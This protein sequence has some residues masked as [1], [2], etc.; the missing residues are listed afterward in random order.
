MCVLLFKGKK[1]KEDGGEMTDVFTQQC[2]PMILI[3]I[4]DI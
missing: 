3:K 4:F 1:K 2:A